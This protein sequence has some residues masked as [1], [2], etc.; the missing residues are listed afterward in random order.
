MKVEM[1]NE[2]DEQ[3]QETGK[4]GENRKIQQIMNTG[5]YNLKQKWDLNNTPPKKKM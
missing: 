5:K 3:E 4:N 2:W 1:K